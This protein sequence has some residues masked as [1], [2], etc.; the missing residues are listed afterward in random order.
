MTSWRSFPGA[1]HGLRASR[2]T[3]A[4]GEEY[5][6]LSASRPCATRHGLRATSTL[7]ITKEKTVKDLQKLYATAGRTRAEL[8][9]RL[10]DAAG[11]ADSEMW[12]AAPALL[13]DME[14][15]GQL[16]RCNGTVTR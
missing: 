16:A 3:T 14:D 15:A 8:E 1:R 13:R 5:D 2:E 12:A 11:A 6:V 7:L 4:V 10:Y 9:Q